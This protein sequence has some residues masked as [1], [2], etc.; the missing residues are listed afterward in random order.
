M[1]D[2]KTDYPWETLDSDFSIVP[3]E[4]LAYYLYKY[5]LD[6]KN[7]KTSLV[8]EELAK[9]ELYAKIL[10]NGRGENHVR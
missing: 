4:L 5:R 1:D 7:R 2:L 10:G 3:S 9:I 8:A 6:I